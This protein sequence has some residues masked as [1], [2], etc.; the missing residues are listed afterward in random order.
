M[1]EWTT[2]TVD[3]VEYHRLHYDGE[4]VCEVEY[5]DSLSSEWSVFLPGS[6][7]PVVTGDNLNLAMAKNR[8]A[9]TWERY[10]SVYDHCAARAAEKMADLR[11]ELSAAGVDL[12]EE[13]GKVAKLEAAIFTARQ[14]HRAEIAELHKRIGDLSSELS[15]EKL[16]AKQLRD[17]LAGALGA[18]QSR[19]WTEEDLRERVWK[20][21]E[22][23]RIERQ[24]EA[25]MQ[26]MAITLHDATVIVY[27][28]T[29]EKIKQMVADDLRAQA[30]ALRASALTPAREVTNG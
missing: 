5:I 14:D 21:G 15:A 6:S 7:D 18:A 16:A 27:D 1:S 23:D 11:I 22:A 17:A 10:R 19:L 26:Y 30:K 8:A 29:R 4:V 3:G 25:V 9:E 20:L 2:E 28:D 13:Q 24:A 12:E